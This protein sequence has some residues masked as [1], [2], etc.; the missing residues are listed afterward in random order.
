MTVVDDGAG[1][2]ER[3]NAELRRRL[4]EREAELAEALEQQTAVAEV[5]QV[6][7]SS[8]GDLE[9]VFDAIL[10][11]AHSLCGAEYG[12]LLT[13]N[14]EA[15]GNARRAAWLSGETGGVS[16]GLRVYGVGAW[17]AISSRTRYG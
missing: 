8:P 1:E 14:G 13:Y 16:P 9:P 2:L 12:V 5:L 7:N 17:G 11:K 4:A 15:G 6:I 3:E 10:E